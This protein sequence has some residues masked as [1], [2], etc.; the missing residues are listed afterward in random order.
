MHALPP[1]KLILKTLER[2][3]SVLVNLK[4]KRK[5]TLPFITHKVSSPS[6]SGL[7]IPTCLP[8]GRLSLHLQNIP[9]E[10]LKQLIVGPRHQNDFLMSNNHLDMWASPVPQRKRMP[11]MLPGQHH[12]PLPQPTTP[13]FSFEGTTLAPF[14][15]QVGKRFKASK[16]TAII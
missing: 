13:L 12:S 16:N 7:E 14:S 1:Y 5:L 10:L 3:P 2:S 6:I 8:W 15:V 9:N 4:T 11:V